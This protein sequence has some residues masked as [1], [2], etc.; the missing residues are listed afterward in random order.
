MTIFR[1]IPLRMR[2]AS[3]KIVEKIKI[4]ILCSTPYSENRA[5]Y[6]TTWKIAVDSGRS[7]VTI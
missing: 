5:V 4:H 1:L 2:N 7:Q 3:D 6:E